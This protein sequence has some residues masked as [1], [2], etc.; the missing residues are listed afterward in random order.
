VRLQLEEGGSDSEFDG[1]VSL[2]AEWYGV[3]RLG[4]D[5]MDLLAPD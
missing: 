4:E 5:C 3:L 2:E 1:P